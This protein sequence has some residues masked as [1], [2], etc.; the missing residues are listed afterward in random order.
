MPYVQKIMDRKEPFNEWDPL[1]RASSLQKAVSEGIK[2]EDLKPK[3][4]NLSKDQKANKQKNNNKKG[5]LKTE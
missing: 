2:K 4:N 5:K 3:E 1:V